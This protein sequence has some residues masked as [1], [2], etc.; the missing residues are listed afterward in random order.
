LS[1][2]AVHWPRFIPDLDQRGL[3]TTVPEP[4]FL[5]HRL[6]RFPTHDPAILNCKACIDIRRLY[7]E[8]GRWMLIRVDRD[9]QAI[10]ALDELLA[11]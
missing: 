7:V 5:Y 4:D 2:G 8:V 1:Y 6:R 9:P 10:E 11:V 3:C